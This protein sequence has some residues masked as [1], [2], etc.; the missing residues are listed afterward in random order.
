MVIDELITFFL[1]GM[2]TI[3]ASTTNLI[4]Y[5]ELNPSIKADLLAEILP[6]AKEAQSNIVEQLDYERV[7]EFELLQRCFYES[8]RIEPPVP[9][10]GAQCMNQDVTI[11]KVAIKRDTLFFIS[12]YSLHHDPS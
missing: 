5:M 9:V 7:M 11:N 3:Q 12:I 10:S 6:A 2:K 8:L 1:A 4:I